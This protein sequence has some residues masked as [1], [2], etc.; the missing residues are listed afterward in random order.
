MELDRIEVA[1]TR[2]SG[3]S[4]GRQRRHLDLVDQSRRQVAERQPK[5][6]T[7]VDVLRA[8][9]ADDQDR[10]VGQAPTDDLEE[11][12]TR[13]VSPV[14]VLEHEH[15]ARANPSKQG[16]EPVE[17]QVAIR[18]GE[19]RA[20]LVVV[21][22]RDIGD[23][24]ERSRRDDRIAPA[25]E[26]G[27]S[28]RKPIDEGVHESGLADSGFARDQHQPARPAPGPAESLSQLGKLGFTLQ[29]LHAAMLLARQLRRTTHQTPDHRSAARGG[30]ASSNRPRFPPSASTGSS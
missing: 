7:V 13:G 25:T 29:D 9:G 21:V 24:R 4:R 26:H 27:G 3:D 12:E 11:I 17:H 16:Q 5:A 1:T 18:R 8:V 10:E 15:T 2:E 30:P 19:R 23:G 6:V 14:E 28:T 22:G 20:E